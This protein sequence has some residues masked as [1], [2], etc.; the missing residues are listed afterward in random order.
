LLSSSLSVS[1]LCIALHRGCCEVQKPPQTNVVDSVFKT[2][3][4]SSRLWGTWVTNLVANFH[5]ASNAFKFQMLPD[6]SFWTVRVLASADSGRLWLSSL[7]R[8]RG[9]QHCAN[10]LRARDILEWERGCQVSRSNRYLSL[11]TEIYLRVSQERERE[12]ERL[13]QK[14]DGNVVAFVF[15]TFVSI[16]TSLG[17]VGNKPCG[18]SVV[19]KTLSSHSHATNAFS[20]RNA[21]Y[22]TVRVLA[23]A[24]FGCRWLSQLWRVTEPA[25]GYREPLW[26]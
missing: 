6:A 21:S 8:S 24:D 14:L 22:W 17:Y 7:A 11:F 5:T 18:Q 10:S 12:R 13:V 9:P 23:F 26:S 15:K 20:K 2:L 25:A 16:I 19:D 4:Q 1:V 3:S